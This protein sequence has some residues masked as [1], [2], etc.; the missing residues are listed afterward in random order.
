M[1]GTRQLS[2]KSF[3]K[4]AKSLGAYSLEFSLSPAFQILRVIPDLVFSQIDRRREGI[5]EARDHEILV[6]SEVG[7]EGS[8]CK[9]T[10][11]RDW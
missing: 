8:G 4:F 10:L 5:K 11:L 3:T 9:H 2:S 1:P 6:K 7:Q